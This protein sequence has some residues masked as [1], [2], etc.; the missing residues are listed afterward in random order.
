MAWRFLY[1]SLASGV[2]IVPAMPA[3]AAGMVL[4]LAWS[5]P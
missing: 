4:P 2:L 3:Q 5:R 1:A